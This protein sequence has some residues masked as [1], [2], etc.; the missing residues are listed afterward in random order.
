MSPKFETAAR[1]ILALVGADTEAGTVAGAVAILERHFGATV[2]AVGTVDR[3]TR[4][5]VGAARDHRD[6]AFCDICQRDTPHDI[7]DDGHERDSSYD[8]RECLECGAV[9]TGM[10]GR[11]TPIPRS[12]R[13]DRMMT[14]DLTGV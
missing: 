2:F 4:R 13:I 11:Y 12:E 9:W 3:W 6:T 7:H 8:R 1:D 5:A 14:R 10:L